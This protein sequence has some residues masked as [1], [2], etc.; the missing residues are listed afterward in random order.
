MLWDRI[1]TWG[2]MTFNKLEHTT[3]TAKI[4][5]NQ[6]VVL[7]S[8]DKMA[9]LLNKPTSVAVETVLATTLRSMSSTTI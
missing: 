9:L 5:H 4:V 1:T 3:P 6:V 7:N 8:T 2:V